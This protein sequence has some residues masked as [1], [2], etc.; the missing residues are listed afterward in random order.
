MTPG[1]TH[2]EKM[3]R[4]TAELSKALRRQAMGTWR[5]VK[6]AN[7]GEATRHAWKFLPT[8]DGSARFLRISH[9]AMEHGDDPVAQLLSSL[10]AGRWLARLDDGP[11]TS[12]MLQADGRLE[13]FSRK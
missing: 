3:A 13:R 4:I 2:D 6:T 12:L 1:E 9:E 10:S 7:R 5:R 8:A 11:E